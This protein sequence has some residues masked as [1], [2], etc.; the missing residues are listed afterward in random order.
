MT[1]QKKEMKNIFILFLVII[2]LASCRNNQNDIPDKTEAK[3]LIL[4][5][6]DFNN[7][8]R[9]WLIA[10]TKSE[11]IN[12]INMYAIKQKDSIEKLLSIADGIIISGGEDINPDI[13]GK[14]EEIV[15]CEEL[16][17]RR[18]SLEQQM[19]RYAL[20][21]QLPIL[22]ICRGHQIMNA[23]NGGT[24]I[25]DIPD[26]TGSSYMHRDKRKKKE[27]M[28]TRTYHTVYLKHN[29]M[30]YGII[31]ADSGQVH[32]NHHQAIEKLAPRFT[33]TSYAKDSIIESFELSD[34]LSH[35]FIL[36]VQW[37]PE[38]MDVGSPFSGNIGRAFMDKVMKHRSKK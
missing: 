19:I 18:D 34:T 23:S 12:C 6:K 37:H 4:I 17:T 31:K 29:T 38:A 14:A 21:H 30:L 32:S 5:S 35:P 27:N 20:D 7:V 1:I 2:G 3:V 36:G 24:L 22:G 13:Y 15:R 16:D 33:P 28:S 8:F 25:I 11:K 26:D 10:S 9:N